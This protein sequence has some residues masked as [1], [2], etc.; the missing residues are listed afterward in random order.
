[1]KIGV[2]GNINYYNKFKIRDFL[3]SLKQKKQNVSVI[4]CGSDSSIDKFVKKYCIEFN[5][6]YEDSTPYHKHWNN[7][8]IEPKYL[9]E[10][11]YSPKWYFVNNNNFVNY[12]DAFVFFGKIDDNNNNKNILEGIKKQNKILKN[13]K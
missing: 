12:C 7:Y 5:I 3:W 13:I 11:A 4:T 2:I 9:Y 10:K 6:K 1:M 8:T